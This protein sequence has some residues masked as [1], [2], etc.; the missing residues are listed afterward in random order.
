MILIIG[1]PKQWS[2]GIP[3]HVP[4]GILAGAGAIFNSHSCPDFSQV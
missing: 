1:L 4:K 2:R 3:T